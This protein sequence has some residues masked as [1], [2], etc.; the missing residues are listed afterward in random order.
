MIK[1]VNEEVFDAQFV[2]N[3]RNDFGKEREKRTWRVVTAAACEGKSGEA[4]LFR[5]CVDMPCC[6]EQL[7]KAPWSFC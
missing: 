2:W 5:L 1:D 6:D 3:S 7:G 4:T